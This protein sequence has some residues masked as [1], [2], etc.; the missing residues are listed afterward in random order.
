M[1]KSARIIVALVAATTFATSTG[2]ADA[3]PPAPP[4]KTLEP[5]SR[6]PVQAVKAVTAPT[7]SG[8]GVGIRVDGGKSASSFAAAGGC[9][10]AT[11]SRS[12]ENILG[13]RLFTYSQ[14]IDWCGSGAGGRITQVSK[15]R[16]VNVNAPGWAFER[17]IENSNTGGAGS[18]S[19]RGYTQGH[20]C[21][22][23]YFNC[24]Q[25]KYPWID[26]TVYPNGTYRHSAG[27]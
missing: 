26:M 5:G 18:A 8:E 25:N 13:M 10:Y 9:W 1:T 22:I 3:A 19:F 2:V 4:I 12:A 17:H 27:G 21:L 15:T 11:T 7:E 20:F 6:V 24:V 14:R 23:A 16:P